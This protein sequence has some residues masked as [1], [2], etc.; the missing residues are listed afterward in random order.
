[1]PTS[2]ERLARSAVLNPITIQVG[3]ANSVADS[4]QQEII[5]VHTVQ[6]K[7]RRIDII[8]VGIFTWN[9]KD[10]LLEIL[11]ST[12]KPPVLVFCNKFFIVDIVV[13][14]LRSEQFHVAG[15]HSQKTQGYR[16]RVMKA[17]KE[18]LNN[19]LQL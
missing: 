4:I 11:R 15:F 10:K 6:K 13:Q 7:V 5:F 8:I 14:F 9:M 18:G 19:C 17:F 16:F 3:E 2:V 12:P 1:M